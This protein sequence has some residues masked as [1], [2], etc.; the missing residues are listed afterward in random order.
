MKIEEVEANTKTIRISSH[1]HVKGLG[2]DEQG[3]PI[4]NLSGLIGQVDAWE[5][6]GVIVELIK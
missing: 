1:S 4:E 5:G 6:C 2:L 3:N